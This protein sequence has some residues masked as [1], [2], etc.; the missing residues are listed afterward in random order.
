MHFAAVLLHLF[1]TVYDT[2]FC[3]WLFG[4]KLVFGVHSLSFVYVLVTVWLIL[5]VLSSGESF[6]QCL[7]F[8][9]CSWTIVPSHESGST[10]VLTPQN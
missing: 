7:V 6:H 8:V 1:L 5:V 2:L 9:G 3:L 4:I 10:V